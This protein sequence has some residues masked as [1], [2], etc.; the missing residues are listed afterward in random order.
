MAV[1]V[2]D[3]TLYPSA[4]LLVKFSAHAR[5]YLESSIATNESSIATNAVLPRPSVY[6]NIVSAHAG[7]LSLFVWMCAP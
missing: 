4:T 2:S 5:V 6:H 7:P 1:F 3:N